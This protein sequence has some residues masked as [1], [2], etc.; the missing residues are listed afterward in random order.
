MSNDLA[1]RR[2]LDCISVAKDI[3]SLDLNVDSRGIDNFCVES[4]VVKF[5]YI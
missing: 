4:N 2:F 5:I 3:I 1:N